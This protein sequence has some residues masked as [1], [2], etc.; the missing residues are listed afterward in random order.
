MVDG[1]GDQSNVSKKTDE[2]HSNDTTSTKS[3]SIRPIEFRYNESNFS[4]DIIQQ[5]AAKVLSLNADSK[6]LYESIIRWMC[7]IGICVPCIYRLCNHFQCI[8][9]QPNNQQLLHS[10]I[11]LER[12]S[13]PSNITNKHCF[14]CNDIYLQLYD[15]VT[16]GTLFKGT[17]IDEYEFDSYFLTP[18]IPPILTMRDFY[19][20]HHLHHQIPSS[21]ELIT[22][23]TNE[24]PDFHRDLLHFIIGTLSNPLQIKVDRT[25]FPPIDG[26]PDRVANK[27][28][29]RNAGDITNSG[30]S[31]KLTFYNQHI[32]TLCGIHQEE[33][34]TMIRS[35]ASKRRQNYKRDWN[36][37][38]NGPREKQICHNCYERGHIAKHC[39][40]KKGTKPKEEKKKVF[41][42]EFKLM[43]RNLP[44][45]WL[46]AHH[47]WTAYRFLTGLDTYRLTLEICNHIKRNGYLQF[48]LP[49]WTQSVESSKSSNG[50]NSSISK[51]LSTVDVKVEITRPPV[52]IAGEYVKYSREISQTPF[53]F[54]KT[55]ISQL[56][57]ETM[58]TF[59]E[60]VKSKPDIT[61]NEI[62][63]DSKINGDSSEL[64]ASSKQ[65]ILNPK[66]DD[67]GFIERDKDIKTNNLFRC[68]CLLFHSAGREDQDVRCLGDGRPLLLQLLNPRKSL[69]FM[70][71]K[72][73]ELKEYQKYCNENVD[74]MI[75]LRN[76][77]IVGEEHQELMKQT[78]N[79][80]KKYYR[81]LC[82]VSRSFE[83][84]EA[85]DQ[86]WKEQAVEFPLTIDQ[87]TP[88]RVLHRRPV[89][90]R[91]KILY[92]IGLKWVTE[93][94]LTVDLLAEAGTYIKEFCHGDRGRTLPNLAT[95]LKCEAANI[96]Q[97]DV[98][99]VVSA[100]FTDR[101]E[102]YTKTE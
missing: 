93:H 72:D 80:K 60:E 76:L 102:M 11:E 36:K 83:N 51:D 87:R 67:R 31:L 92:E 5:I 30:I 84:Q 47:V 15:A 57:I 44:K 97:L 13:I 91:P 56:I 78:E 100:L 1:S 96:H 14:I 43:E 10:L 27:F 17:G 18:N 82:W 48:A 77:R 3:P 25:R 81:A 2:S 53:P 21:S 49:P 94:W 55:S 19:V 23:P 50:S 26:H 7:K 12:T 52:Y 62:D 61:S 101:K 16:K 68:D 66:S 73:N 89:L 88:I 32:Q 33:R 42:G 35:K 64:S 38:D 45:Q 28:G 22:F 90:N 41:C 6:Q 20:I 4:D 37:K 46:K 95:L 98:T 70:D 24:T 99:K 75:E 29:F 65:E 69:S 54:A 8:S 74:G 86:F 58:R 59:K 9:H 40:S 71:E 79:Q 63:G 34:S 85:L 39:P